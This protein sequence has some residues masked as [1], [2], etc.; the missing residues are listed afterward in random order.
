MKK[1]SKLI[2][3]VII[4]L[5]GMMTTTTGA[6]FSQQDVT[7][8][9]VLQELNGVKDE[10]YSVDLTELDSPRSGMERIE[11]YPPN[12]YTSGYIANIWCP[13]HD[14]LTGY[15]VF[16]VASGTTVEVARRLFANPQIGL[17]RVMQQMDVGLEDSIK[18]V[19]IEISRETYEGIDWDDAK[20]QIKNDPEAAFDILGP[21]NINVKGASGYE[22][23]EQYKYN[24]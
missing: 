22:R 7:T 9:T 11:V 5:S 6:E 10:S 14:Y 24:C 12:D 21:C 23:P 20:E 2:I 15:N 17:L 8:E 13:P 1:I 4:F 18:A 3:T 16:D 19:Q